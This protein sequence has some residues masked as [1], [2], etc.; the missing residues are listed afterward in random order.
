[1]EN[2]RD[3]SDIIEEIILVSQCK[4]HEK[5]DGSK[6]Q[7][8]FTSSHLF[9]NECHTQHIG[10]FNTLFILQTSYM[11]IKV[12]GKIVLQFMKFI[13]VKIVKFQLDKHKGQ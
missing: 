3:L 2:V 10:Q 5:Y 12:K 1:M 8:K 11:C 9:A 6:S 4:I 7:R 13:S